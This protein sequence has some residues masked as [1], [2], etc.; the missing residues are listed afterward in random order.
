[1]DILKEGK[2]G[3]VAKLP[4]KELVQLRCQKAEDFSFQILNA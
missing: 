4:K 2:C 1:M 3:K